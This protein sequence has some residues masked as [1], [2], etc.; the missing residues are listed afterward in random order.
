M[1]I[2]QRMVAERKKK[3]L[4][5]RCGHTL[6]FPVYRFKNLLKA[7][8]DPPMNSKSIRRLTN[9]S[10]SLLLVGCVNSNLPAGA[11]LVGGGLDI[12][13]KPDVDGTLILRERTSGRM[14]ATASVS[15]NDSAP[16]QFGSAS[17]P[18]WEA[19]VFSLFPPVQGTNF[20][21][22]PSLPTNTFFE[23]YFV[24]ANAGK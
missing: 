6:T 13:Y 21:S 23:L 22:T 4:R 17:T 24:P 2:L 15:A 20:T 7:I 9:G 19:T 16:W 10:I 3:G 18:N 8:A 12:S 5:H 14:V 1:R 11:K